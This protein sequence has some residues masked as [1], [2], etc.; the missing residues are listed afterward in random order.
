MTQLHLSDDRL[1]GSVSS[2]R[3]IVEQQHLGAVPAAARGVRLRNLLDVSEAAVTNADA[4]FR[5]TG[6]RV[7]RPASFAPKRRTLAG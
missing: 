3:S 4:A 2:R 7:S 5:L 6:S 1:I